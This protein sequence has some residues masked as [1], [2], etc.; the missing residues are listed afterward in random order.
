MEKL[1]PQAPTGEAVAPCL[2]RV[3]TLWD[4]IVCGTAL[5]QPKAP[6][7]LFGGAQM[8]P[9][10]HYATTLLQAMFPMLITA[11]SYGR[12]AALSPCRRAMREPS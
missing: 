6:V 10:G 3:L 5:T 12:M 4:L 11:S 1:S 7:P 8:L 2:R 9:N